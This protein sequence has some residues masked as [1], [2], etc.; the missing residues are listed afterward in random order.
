MLSGTTMQTKRGAYSLEE[1]A[2]MAGVDVKRVIDKAG[3]LGISNLTADTSVC[4]IR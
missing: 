1:I 3:A 2:Q 4:A